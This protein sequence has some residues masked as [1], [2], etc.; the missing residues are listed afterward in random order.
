M[1]LSE[2]ERS[3]SLRCQSRRQHLLVY[4]QMYLPPNHCDV[5]LML[6]LTYDENQAIYYF[7]FFNY[8]LILSKLKRTKDIVSVKSSTEV[9]Y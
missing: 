1:C 2:S 8:I 5:C 6:K 4:I 3:D 9:I 7:Y